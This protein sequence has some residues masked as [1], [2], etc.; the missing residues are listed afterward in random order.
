[1]LIPLPESTLSENLSWTRSL[2]WDLS[3][4]GASCDKGRDVRKSVNIGS[5]SYAVRELE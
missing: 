2:Y 1:M 4:E 5:L 3:L